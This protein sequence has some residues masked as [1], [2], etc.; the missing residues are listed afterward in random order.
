MI[1]SNQKIVLKLCLR[2]STVSHM[3]LTHPQC[4]DSSW[5]CYQ[6]PT[7]CVC[8]HTLQRGSRCVL[9]ESSAAWIGSHISADNHI[10][11]CVC[12]LFVWLAHFLFDVSLF[13]AEHDKPRLPPAPSLTDLLKSYSR[14]GR[15][16][17]QK[18]SNYPASAIETN[19]RWERW[20][21]CVWYCFWQAADAL[22]Y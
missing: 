3:M 6:M 10:L 1:Q 16:N 19:R 2:L 18:P 8:S 11:W 13:Q 21:V 22:C 15:K 17:T 9:A 4:A 5:S 14:N 7:L 12:F 20:C